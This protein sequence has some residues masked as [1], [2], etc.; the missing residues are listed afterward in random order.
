MRLCTLGR[1]LI[2]KYSL[3][4]I[5]GIYQFSLTKWAILL[6]YMFAI[7]YVYII[8]STMH[9]KSCFCYIHILA[10]SITT[11]FDADVVQGHMPSTLSPMTKKRKLFYVNLIK[12]SVI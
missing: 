8:A 9:D 1:L 10:D 6:G 2:E 3:P 12:R 4:A 5:S 11:V 7:I